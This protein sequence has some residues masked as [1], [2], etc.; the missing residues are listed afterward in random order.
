[1]SSI[2]ASW[3]LSNFTPVVNSGPLAVGY[4][5]SDYS[6][7]ELEQYLENVD[8]WNEG[9]LVQQEIGRRKI[10]LVGIFEAPTAATESTVLNDGK[11]IKT[12]LNWLLSAGQTVNLFTYNLGSGSVSTTIP[13][14]AVRG[15][16][17]LWAT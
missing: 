14:V 10:R 2:V 4:C 9:N 8:S 16:A 11:P 3:T 13:K 5:H 1:M 17:N 7:P 6:T 12:K 15:H